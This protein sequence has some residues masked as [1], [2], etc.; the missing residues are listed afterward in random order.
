MVATPIILYPLCL[1]AS[2]LGGI[3]NGV[4]GFGLAVMF[5]MIWSISNLCGYPYT[6]SLVFPVILQTILAPI[7]DIVL[8]YMVGKYHI[9]ST[10][11]LSIVIS[12]GM[13][14]GWPIGMYGLVI[15]PIEI[16]KLSLGVFFLAFVLWRG[17]DIYLEYKLLLDNEIIPLEDVTKNLPEILELSDILNNSNIV[18]VE[19]ELSNIVM[20]N[21]GQI[22]FENGSNTGI[23]RKS[24]ITIE[25]NNKSDNNF[26]NNILSPSDAFKKIQV[27]TRRFSNEFE[28]PLVI[29]PELI[30]VPVDSSKDLKSGAGDKET[31]LWGVPMRNFTNYEY[32]LTVIASFVAG[33]IG[34]A[35]GKKI[36]YFC[37]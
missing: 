25:C 26:D 6:D 5:L 31:V 19:I 15:L 29:E 3:S 4:T 16:L 1:I 21:S 27:Q 28:P 13:S 18:N 20:D 23:K 10:I 35:F 7:I 2:L 34:G 11:K 24:T 22:Y 12:I 17:R 30:E 33:L 37:F 9:I 32:M 14:V 8:V 36:K